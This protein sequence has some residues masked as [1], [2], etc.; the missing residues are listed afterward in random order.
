MHLKSPRSRDGIDR[1]GLQT[2]L[3][4]AAQP[5]S[6][7]EHLQLCFLPAKSSVLPHPGLPCAQQSGEGCLFPGA[8]PTLRQ[9]KHSR[10]PALSSASPDLPGV[11]GGGHAKDAE[12]KHRNTKSD[13]KMLSVDPRLLSWERGAVL[14][15]SKPS[16]HHSIFLGL[17]PQGSE[18]V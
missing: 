17:V 9:K 12:Q 5:P 16:H 14:I 3:S 10:L 13:E 2:F 11:R 1:R 7:P 15:M 8:T 18:A 6:P 4:S